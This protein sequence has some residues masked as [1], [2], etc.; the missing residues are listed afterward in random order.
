MAPAIVLVAASMLQT[1]CMSLKYDHAVDQG[2]VAAYEE[3]A[4]QFPDTT[5]GNRALRA[6]TILDALQNAEP[7]AGTSLTLHWKSRSGGKAR[8]ATLVMV[9]H[10]FA[11]RTV[12]DPD[13]GVPDGT[14]LLL[15]AGSRAA[16]LVSMLATQPEAEDLPPHT[17]V[18]VKLYHGVKAHAWASRG[19]S[20]AVF[21]R[22]VSLAPLR[23]LNEVTADDV[24][25]RWESKTN[26]ELRIDVYPL[27]EGEA[28][29]VMKGGHHPPPDDDP[30]GPHLHGGVIIHV[31]P[32][33]VHHPHRPHHGPGPR[34]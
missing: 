16:E 30:W 7:L 13:P 10:L 23:S 28:E 31:G 6:A 8:G 11:G 27:D 22:H 33:R 20:R 3:F 1:G 5:K 24:T 21:Q 12:S 17:T 29:L 19:R 15:V 4:K 25:S 34:W 14:D 26:Y 9:A 18:Y 2:T 32:H